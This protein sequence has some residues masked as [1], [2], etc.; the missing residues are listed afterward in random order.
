MGADCASDS[1]T[2]VAI[3]KD[4]D[5]FVHQEGR[6]TERK[7]GWIADLECLRRL[8]KDAWDEE[9]DNGTKADPY[10]RD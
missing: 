10:R 2:L 3:A 6:R 5:F 8:V 4:E 9:P 1:E 7:V